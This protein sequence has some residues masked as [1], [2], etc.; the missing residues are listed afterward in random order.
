MRSMEQM[1][2]ATIE[3]RERDFAWSEQIAKMK[4]STDE[5][6]LPNWVNVNLK[7]FEQVSPTFL[8]AS[9]P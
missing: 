7:I 6:N 1:H 4:R 8:K 9:F 2:C 5:I 3:A